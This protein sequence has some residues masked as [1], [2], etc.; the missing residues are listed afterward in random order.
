MGIPVSSVESESRT[1]RLSPLRPSARLG[2]IVDLAWHAQ[3][4]ASA[5]E[6]LGIDPR[7]D[8]AVAR[9]VEEIAGIV[10]SLLRGVEGAPPPGLGCCRHAG[11]ERTPADREMQAA[12]RAFEMA[13]D[14]RSREAFSALLQRRYE[15]NKATRAK[16]GASCL[17]P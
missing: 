12:A 6:Q 10:N 17:M 13:D 8:P 5:R 14:D 7:S 15:A 4:S 16:G 1:A 9:Q 11:P 2:L 3:A